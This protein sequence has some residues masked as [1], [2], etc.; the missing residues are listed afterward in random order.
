MPIDL[1]LGPM[2]D[3]FQLAFVRQA[4]T[5]RIGLTGGDDVGAECL[6]G[7]ARGRVLFCRSGRIIDP[8]A[9]GHLERGTLKGTVVEQRPPDRRGHRI[10]ARLAA[11]YDERDRHRRRESGEQSWVR[12]NAY[13]RDWGLGTGP[14]STRASVVPFCATMEEVPLQGVTDRGGAAMAPPRSI[15]RGLLPQPCSVVGASGRTFGELAQ[16]LERS[17][18]ELVQGVSPRRR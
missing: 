12:H 15:A 2:V 9:A 3:P 14:L 8:A 6:V 7:V 5:I 16:A 18:R 13:L 4:R 11:R 1:H 10:A 17:V